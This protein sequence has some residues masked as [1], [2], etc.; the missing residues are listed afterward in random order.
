MLA[1]TLVFSAI[2]SCAVVLERPD[3]PVNYEHFADFHYGHAMVGGVGMN[4]CTTGVT[5]ATL[6]SDPKKTRVIVSFAF[7]H[8]GSVDVG[9]L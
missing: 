7:A 9:D 3:Q 2:L 1:C 8:A 6:E 5:I 4:N